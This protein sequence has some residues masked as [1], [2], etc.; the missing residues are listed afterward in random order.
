M[1][2][3]L[4]FAEESTAQEQLLAVAMM[5]CR[6]LQSESFITLKVP[7][8]VHL[9]LTPE[10]Y[11]SLLYDLLISIDEDVSSKIDLIV[12]K[13]PYFQL[14]STERRAPHVFL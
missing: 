6:R 2:E 11:G 12:H 4:N 9:N 14:I 3:I 10:N 1:N 13:K 8:S 5:I 7:E